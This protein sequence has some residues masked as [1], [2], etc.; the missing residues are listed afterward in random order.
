MGRT[1]RPLLFWKCRYRLVESFMSLVASNTSM[2][3]PYYCTED[4]EDLPVEVFAV[5]KL[6]L[7][8]FESALRDLQR[9]GILRKNALQWFHG[10]MNSSITYQDFLSI[11]TL[12]PAREKFVQDCLAG[13]VMKM[14][15]RRIAYS[16][17]L[18][19]SA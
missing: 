2:K 7:A 4:S 6:F 11:Y 15:R 18:L 5:R 17:S 3:T 14:R 10:E 1:R 12:S 9:K 16:S 8:V 13:K 19:K